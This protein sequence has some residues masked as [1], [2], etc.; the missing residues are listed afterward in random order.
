MVTQKQKKED[1]VIKTLMD[2]GRLPTGRLA[3]IVGLGYNQAIELF[4]TMWEE[5]KIVCDV[6]TIA[7]YWRLKDETIAPIPAV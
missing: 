2:H 6:E 5:K 3:S 1:K 7:T 4:Q